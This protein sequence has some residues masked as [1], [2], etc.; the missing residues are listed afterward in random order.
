MPSSGRKPA[1]LRGVNVISFW[2]FVSMGRP[3]WRGQTAWYKALAFFIFGSPDIHTRLRN[4][5][6]LNQINGLPMPAESHVLEA[7]AGRAI[8][9]FWLAGRHPGWRLTGI[10]LDPVLAR[11][12][13]SA[14]A[15]TGFKNISLIE[16]N[17]LELDAESV[18]DL[19]ICIDTL[20]HIQDDVGLLR[21]FRD[22]LRPG[23]YVVIHVPRR[24]QQMWRW[25]PVFH[26]HGVVGHHRDT[27]VAGERRRIVIEGHVR[28][29]YTPEE[30]QQ[31]AEE[32]GF[33]AVTV[34]ETIGRL[35]EISFE[36]NN[37]FWT[38]P[39]L[40]YLLALLTYPIAIVLA[41]LDV[42]RNPAQGNS[43]LLTARR[44]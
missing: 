34:R 37:L 5:Y 10:E 42:K 16:G 30:L 39:T 40:R 28:E 3:H 15:Y 23:G 7:G 35:G 36:L 17:I 9:L 13:Q 27:Y 22:T 21:R 41:Y 14:L 8:P 4:S 1:K 44:S 31:V 20:E 11:S 24:H 32:A 25:L 18:Y 2:D 29:E 12:T 33:T 43:L 26:H 38:R 19:V 6:V